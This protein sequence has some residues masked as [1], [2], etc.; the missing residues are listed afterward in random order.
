MSA[1]RPPPYEHTSPEHPGSGCWGCTPLSHE[2][3]WLRFRLASA[4]RVVEA[5]GEVVAKYDDERNTFMRQ[6][7]TASGTAITFLHRD[8][9]AIAAIRARLAEHRGTK[10][11]RK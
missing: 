1:P 3:D 5:A 7:P 8:P 9:P 4:E 11:V 2:L 6:N 10:E